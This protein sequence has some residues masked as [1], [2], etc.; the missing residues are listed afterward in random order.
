MADP[1]LPNPVG[2]DLDS[3][4]DLPDFIMG[5][6]LAAQ[7]AANQ[8]LDGNAD[9][10]G[11]AAAIGHSTGENPSLIYSDLENYERQHKAILTSKLLE[12][13]DTLR[14]YALAHPLN[15]VI[16][17][18]D[19][20]QL[21]SVSEAIKQFGKG[22]IIKQAVEQFKAQQR[23]FMEGWGDEE[24]GY[25]VNRDQL[26]K[27][28]TDY[29]SVAR[30]AVRP[31]AGLEVGRE[32]L[33]RFFSGAGH[34]LLES[35][36]E[37][38]KQLG[39]DENQARTR[40][41]D[42]VGMFDSYLQGTTGAP[43]IPEAPPA[44]VGR[45]PIE[46]AARHMQAHVDAGKHPLPGEAA[47]DQMIAADSK[48]QMKNLDNIVKETAKSSTNEASQDFPNDPIG[49]RSFLES[50]PE[51]RGRMIGISQDGL[52]K[53]YPEGSVP[54]PGDGKLGGVPRIA[55]AIERARTGGGDVQVPLADMIMNKDMYDE[56]KDHIRTYAQGK[57]LEEMK[58]PAKAPELEAEKPELAGPDSAAGAIRR[59][60]GIDWTQAGGL[61]DAPAGKDM[62]PYEAAE[63]GH[64]I[65]RYGGGVEQSLH[66]FKLA[67]VVPNLDFSGL[68]KPE[69]VIS[70]YFGEYLTRV[71]GDTPV[72]VVSAD[73]MERLTGMRRARG[74]WRDGDVPS[75]IVLREDVAKGVGQTAQSQ[76][77]TVIHE[78]IHAI[79]AKALDQYEDLRVAVNR[80]MITAESYLTP[81]ERDIHD[82]AFTN[83]K[84]FMAE[85]ISKASLRERLSTIPIT[86]SLAATLKLDQ[87]TGTLWDGL[88]EILKRAWARITGK[89]PTHSVM[90]A[91]FRLA[92]VME[93]LNRRDTMRVGVRPL[94][95]EGE[96]P[97]KPEAMGINKK[98]QD[99]LLEMIRRES[100]K[101]AEQRRQIAE[102][103]VAQRLKKEWKENEGI[104][105]D[106][107]VEELQNRPDIAAD[108]FL[109]EGQ[110][111]GGKVRRTRLDQKQLTDEQKAGLSPEHYGPDGMSPDDA[112]GL[113]FGRNSGDALVKALQ[114]LEAERK[115][116]DLTP[117]AHFNQLRDIETERRMK[118]LY[119]KLDENILA[120]AKDHALNPITMDRLHEQFVAYGMKY[121]T[122]TDGPITKADI[123]SWAEK[124]FNET[125]IKEHDSDKYLAEM[126]RRFKDYVKADLEERH[127]DAYKA[128][129]QH[130][131]QGYLA[132]LAATYEREQSTFDR[133]K[134]QVLKR[135]PPGRAEEFANWNHFQLAKGGLQVLRRPEDLAERMDKYAAKTFLSF[136]EEKSGIYGLPMDL[137]DHVFDDRW[138]KPERD[139][140]YGEWKG[141]TGAIKT[142]DNYAID[143]SK[144][145]KLGKDIDWAGE[146][147]LRPRLIEQAK[148]ESFAKP[149]NYN[150]TPFQKLMGDAKRLAYKHI[151]LDS[152][153]ARLDHYNPYGLFQT[154]FSYDAARHM[155]ALGIWL[156]EFQKDLNALS[157]YD[158][159]LRKKV[160]NSLLVH[161]RTREP[162]GV[163][164]E[165]VRKLIT[166]LGTK[167]GE[168]KVI[169]GWILPQQYTK[170]DYEAAK[171]SLYDWLGKVSDK[172]DWDFAQGL[173][174][175]NEKIYGKYEEMATEAGAVPAQREELNPINIHGKTFKGGYVKLSYDPDILGTSKKLMGSFDPE[176]AM[177]DSGFW[178]ASTP[179][180]HEKART[181]YA[182][183]LYLK[184]DRDNAQMT[185]VLRDAAM[186]P[187]I[188]N[189]SKAFYD[190][191]F[192]D[193]IQNA[194]G[195]QVREMLNTYLR[196]VTGMG[197]R[198]NR[199]DAVFDRLVNFFS[200][201]LISRMIGINVHTIAK[202]GLSAG[203]NSLGEVGAINVA[204]EMRAV[205]DVG[206]LDPKL[207]NEDYAM[208]T[209][210]EL[211][212][213]LRMAGGTM[214]GA[215]EK[216]Q[217][218]ESWRDWLAE[219]YAA[220]IG[221]FDL[222][223]AVPT[224]IV[225]FKQSKIDQVKATGDVNLDLA[226]SIA[227]R[228]VR[229]AHGSTLMTSRPEVMQGGAL[230]RTFSRLYLFFNTMLQRNYEAYARSRA[231][232]KEFGEWAQ[233]KDSAKF[234]QG[235]EDIAMA[236]K[237]LVM[238][239]LAPALIEE[240]VTP[241]KGH[242]KDNW[243]E[244]SA[245][246]LLMMMGGM[247][248]GVRE[249][250]HAAIG[251]YEP[252]LGI[253][254][255][256]MRD[257][258][259]LFKDLK[260]GA[261]AFDN[262]HGGKTIKELNSLV[263]TFKGYTN[264]RIGNLMKW[265]WDV[266]HP[267][268]D[269]PR[270]L[271][272]HA[273]E[274]TSGKPREKR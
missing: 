101:I 107:V 228:A 59:A 257:T 30:Y 118:L 24:L 131:I 35:L 187:F 176:D 130:Q 109:R 49:Y 55:E 15:P 265:G 110:L 78:G 158:T 172:K 22:P 272:E 132:K 9:D 40:A 16:S 226:V 51:V 247:I 185:N 256:G 105:R 108:R 31:L 150:L 203:I 222:K 127:A 18:N 151:L 126:G 173:W 239:N 133:L 186:R 19:W 213:R 149:F 145:R 88:K 117:T 268:K 162:I 81:A 20:G 243:G 79:T 165:N 231:G 181:G 86:E 124:S 83:A 252:G 46:A 8:G 48:L 82:Y 34:A 269:T 229:R 121:G 7:A 1:L 25:S 113:F 194:A 115:L 230:A 209:S 84:E 89:A 241:Y 167:T 64:V 260:N 125:P 103:E 195:V 90:D 144:I 274:I 200:G 28:L 63:S 153:W 224:W 68:S 175:V 192:L 215:W 72:H 227:D 245:K 233:T 184:L 199:S 157:E 32:I 163:N 12:D 210:R 161:P 26:N 119:G 3:D 73:G 244:W 196:N 250:I 242:D 168:D 214:A 44:E 45:S 216:L 92:D 223:T 62:I 236:A 33:S 102:R 96:E 93:E 259:Q 111:Y 261:R 14:E 52:D 98:Q 80:A 137:A 13:N 207:S 191:K 85:A 17:Q 36:V 67:D 143:A 212:N 122:K 219:K 69:Q 253:L 258:V 190:E 42:L 99:K 76:S 66:S 146:D 43:H 221:Y 166:Y 254:D 218:K 27:F 169:R 53:L 112:A 262:E 273:R 29:P 148:K 147:G 197:P 251:D 266:T 155:G 240:M 152:V 95:E 188:I 116:A 193:A 177:G 21:H 123:K 39:L 65:P 249:F 77:R 23:G 183:P 37:G 160:E 159:N 235:K 58:G 97:I 170:G 87:K 248:P 61:T 10:A 267:N 135:A 41:R 91:V 220:P 174:N 70:N 154:T 270:T 47:T 164:K 140:T 202:H 74:Y 237:A 106:K 129:Q 180:S 271:Y 225:A 201:N 114:D 100:E 120:E 138:K 94:L 57:T 60:T 264:D 204:R 141:W 179:R 50:H 182:G 206:D 4:D 211:P 71:A 205:D 234:Q 5:R 156:R 56:V 139:M 134:K 136:A 104:V 208:R 263:G 54:E 2:L 255:T 217:G 128:L 198:M 238:A 11:R 142:I 171:A 246:T 6:R 178:R 189:A 232:V 38:Q 75:H